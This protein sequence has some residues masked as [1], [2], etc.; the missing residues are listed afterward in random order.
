MER[1]DSENRSAGRFSRGAYGQHGFC[2]PKHVQTADSGWF[3]AC[4]RLHVCSWRFQLLAQAAA[5]HGSGVW[6]VVAS[7]RLCTLARI[8]SSPQISATTMQ[9]WLSRFLA[10]MYPQECPRLEE[11]VGAEVC[12][13]PKCS[14]LR[15]GRKQ[16][17]GDGRGL[18]R[19]IKFA[20]KRREQG[21]MACNFTQGDGENVA[22]TL[23][24]LS[25]KQYGN[26]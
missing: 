4:W 26:F 3:L 13:P 19:S 9:R 12:S 8:S 7:V 10:W 23:A 25:Q 1:S 24:N 11:S 16:A 14:V 20:P 21:W 17:C 15:T 6:G 2:Y 18:P 22:V 5:A